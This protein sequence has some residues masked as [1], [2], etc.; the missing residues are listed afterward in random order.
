MTRRR[1][2]AMAPPQIHPALP[3]PNAGGKWVLV[4]LHGKCESARTH[5][6]PA[7]RPASRKNPGA[8][9]RCEFRELAREGPPTRSREDWSK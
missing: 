7:G 1:S 6:S 8:R 4:A 5:Q 9:G 2:C 3:R